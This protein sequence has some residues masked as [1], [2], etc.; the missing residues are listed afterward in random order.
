[1]TNEAIK[2]VHLIPHDGLGGVEVAARSMAARENAPCDFQLLLIAGPVIGGDRGRIIE[3]PYASPL[4]PLAQFRALKLCLRA[5]PDILIFS[6]WRSFAVALAMRILRPRTRIVFFLNLTR[7]T[8]FVDAIVSR[9]AIAIADAVWADSDA[10]L[11]QRL[12]RRN[13]P[14][15]VISF[16]T[17]RLAPA[18]GTVPIAPKP[19]FVSWSRL[20]RQKGID[21]ALRFINLLADM[22]ADARFDVWGPDDGALP[23]LRKLA[24]ELGIAKRVTFHGPAARDELPG[25]AAGASF[26]LQLSRFEGMAMGTVEAM[27]LGLVPVVTAVGE[28]SRYVVD[29]V[30]GVI[31]DPDRPDPAIREMI[32]LLDEPERYRLIQQRAA[33]CWQRA[34]LYADDICAAAA[35]LGSRR[36]TAAVLGS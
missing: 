3:S 16:V 8:H 36:G 28:M 15:R 12:G 18:A 14:S 21:R 27:Q 25:I 20:N 2:I 11:Q 23:R 4:N 17:D 10:T 13:K 34:P 6:L 31:V 7:S 26:F 24:D 5:R 30:T 9:M 1:M 22:G 19:R 32:R 35:E 33:E 29:G